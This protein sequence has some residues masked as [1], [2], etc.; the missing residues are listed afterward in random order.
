MLTRAHASLRARRSQVMQHCLLYLLMYGLLLGLLAAG[1]AS[2]MVLDESSRTRSTFAHLTAALTAGRPVFGF[3]G[4]TLINGVGERWLRTRRDGALGSG[5][6]ASAFSPVLQQ[7]LINAAAA[8]GGATDPGPVPSPAGRRSSGR[9]SGRYED[10]A[11]EAGF[12]EELRYELVSDVARAISELAEREVRARAC[13]S[14][15]ASVRTR[16]KVARARAR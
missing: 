3:L 11:R 12:K 10:A 4:W 16:T 6:F 13:A 7:P 1:Y 15:E 2:M 5:S 9:D 14:A 8:V